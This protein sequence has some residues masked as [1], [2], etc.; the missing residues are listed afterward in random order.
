MEHASCSCLSLP[1]AEI[2]SLHQYAW[3]H[4]SFIGKNSGCFVFSFCVLEIQESREGCLLSTVTSNHY[5]LIVVPFI[6]T[7]EK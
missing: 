2:T 4:V 7:A 3:A 1:S 5:W 6:N